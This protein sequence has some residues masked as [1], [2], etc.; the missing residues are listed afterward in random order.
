LTGRIDEHLAVCY[1]TRADAAVTLRALKPALF[2]RS[3]G[4]DRARSSRKPSRRWRW[5]SHPHQ[6]SS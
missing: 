1:G 3:R 5:L 2:G 4:W 6:S